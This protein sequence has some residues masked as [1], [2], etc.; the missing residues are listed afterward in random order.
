[1]KDQEE[2]DL[3][4]VRKRS[5]EKKTQRILRVAMDL[6][7]EEGIDGLTIHRLARELDV[8]VGA[9]Y[10]YF[11]SKDALL[12]T[13]QCDGMTALQLAM[14]EVREVCGEWMRE[15]QASADVIM[16]T[17]YLVWAEFYGKFARTGSAHYRLLSLMLGHPE[18]LVNDGDAARVLEAVQPIFLDI[19]E[20]LESSVSQGVLQVGD[21]LDRALVLW[22][23]LYGLVQVQKVGRLA[24]MWMR[25][26]RL[27][28]QLMTSLLL[29]WGAEPKSLEQSLQWLVRFGEFFSYHELATLDKYSAIT[30]SFTGSFGEAQNETTESRADEVVASVDFRE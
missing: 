23:S 8:T 6:V 16:L 15:K 5:R 25:Q 17:Q 10:R 4:P 14:Q 27:L 29:G 21:A 26:E 3:S 19:V 13:L 12:V 2:R 30:G 20:H 28:R 1:M 24:P 11:S 9:L 22:S 18:P 7:K